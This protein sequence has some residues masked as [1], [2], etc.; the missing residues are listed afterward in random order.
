M[1]VIR[2]IQSRIDDQIQM[3]LD[4][5]RKEAVAKVNAS[6]GSTRQKYITI[7]PGQEMI[8]QAKEAEAIRFM[9]AD[10]MPIDLVDYPFIQAE[11]GV[12]AETAYEV[13]AIWLGMSQYW[14]TVAASLEQLRMSAVNAIGAA[15]DVASIE[16][17][18]SD[19]NDAI[20]EF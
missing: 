8:Y 14:R 18:L 5:H 2:R 3:N 6:I 11:V 10:P 1:A 15:N 13:A 17:A 20:R 16:Q 4:V 7:I 12:L 19:F 9:N